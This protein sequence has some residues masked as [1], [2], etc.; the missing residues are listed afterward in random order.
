MPRSRDAVNW[1]ITA[2][3]TAITYAWAGAEDDAVELLEQL[4]TAVPG[5]APAE[6]TAPI[7]GPLA[8]N[9]RYEALAQKLKA[10]MAATKL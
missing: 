8:K 4:S 9:A 6:I 10:Q 7:F 3:L 1:A 2:Y 5:V